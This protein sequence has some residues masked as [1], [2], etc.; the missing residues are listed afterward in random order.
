MF[1]ALNHMT[2]PNLDMGQFLDLAAAL[3]C[4]GVELRND[5]ARPLFDGRGPA[6]A[7]KEIAARG[8]RLV[9]LS[10][11][12]PFNSWTPAIEA[13]VQA[14]IRTAQEAG[15]ETIS[16]IPR[17]D[18]TMTDPPA[19]QEALARALRGVLP[20]LEAADMVALVEPLG[21]ERSSLRLKSELVAAIDAVGGAGRFRLVHDTFH[22]A[23]A[24][25]GPMFPD[26]T[27]IVHV[28]AVVDPALALNRMEDEHRVLVFEDDRLD[29]AGQLAALF[30]AGYAGP[31]SYECFS[32]R[33]HALTD[34]GAEIGRSMR[35]VEAAVA[36]RRK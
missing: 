31:V 3:G 22:H 26:R 29:N 10:Q 32:P 16:L 7:R 13:E 2:T 27:G 25:G 23:L 1:W 36:A 5:L 17:N 33:T 20:M 34:P 28:S 11:V 9:G 18:G 15:A 8:L 12:Y 30:D 24:H 35:F 21:F 19:R 6:E 14:L 4:G